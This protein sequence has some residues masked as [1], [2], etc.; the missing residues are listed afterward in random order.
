[1]FGRTLRAQP[2]GMVFAK[3]YIG[4]GMCRERLGFVEYIGGVGL[5]CQ[6]IGGL[7]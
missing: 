1:M 5:V 7:G 6:Y 4:P 2:K 3:Q